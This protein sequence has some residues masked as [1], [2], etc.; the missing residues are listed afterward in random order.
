ML[1]LV[2]TRYTSKAQCQMFKISNLS[3]Y[4]VELIFNSFWYHKNHKI[5]MLVMLFNTTI[6]E[7][8]FIQQLS[9]SFTIAIKV[10]TTASP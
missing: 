9:K 3:N 7:Q 8:Y 2:E 4:R 6:R 1:W 10:L 5:I